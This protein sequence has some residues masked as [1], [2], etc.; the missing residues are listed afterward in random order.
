MIRTV[1]A[2]CLVLFPVFAFA[3]SHMHVFLPNGDEA[4]L[5]KAILD[6]NE[7]PLDFTTVI[8]ISGEYIIP[9]SDPLP[10]IEGNITIQGQGIF[11]GQDQG[12]QKLFSIAEDAIFGLLNIEFR[13]YSLDNSNAGGLIENFGRMD[14]RQVQLRSVTK[15]CGGPRCN[16]GMPAITNRP[17]GHIQMNQVSFVNSGVKY[18]AFGNGS[19]LIFNEGRMEI[20]N[21]QLYLTR[22]RWSAPISNTGSLQIGNSSFKFVH[23]PGTSALNLVNS[24]DSASTRIFNS[25]IAGFSGAW[26]QQATSLG[27]NLNDAVDC[28]WNSAGDL[29]GVPTGLLWRPV[30]A[31]WSG[32]TPLLT[33]GLVPMAA[34]AAVD[35]ANADWCLPVTLLGNVHGIYDGNGDGVASCDR[36]P[37][38]LTPIGLE[39]GGINGFYFDPNADGHYLYIL[40]N[41]FNTLVM[42]TTFDS[43][44]RQLWVYGTGE[45]KNG[46]SLTAKAYINRN[47]KVGLDGQIEPAND[48]H[49]GWLEVDMTSCTEGEVG[50]RSDLPEFGSGQF[51]IQRL[52]YV[53][54]LGCID[55]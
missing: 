51:S 43:E 15:P 45:L 33:H 46:R 5:R 23:L 41:D 31:S 36:G 12:A 4:A 40:E 50:F 39:D 25:V 11:E 16:R 19:A 6:A 32:I 53:K 2:F 3:Q 14:F 52:A 24:T 26:C 7:R 18:D 38:D 9:A 27:Y 54:Q 22:E 8:V 1:L 21:L 49:W 37:I 28:G 13:N 42:W 44:G 35:S 55:Q 34:S 47:G 17:S 30:S 48:E 20:A 29:T 10:P